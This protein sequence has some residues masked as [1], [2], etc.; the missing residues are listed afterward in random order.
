MTWKDPRDSFFEEPEEENEQT[1]LPEGTGMVE[2]PGVGMVPRAMMDEGIFHVGGTDPAQD[3]EAMFVV[4]PWLRLMLDRVMGRF[5]EEELP[6]G[7]NI[8]AW[9]DRSLY[10][11]QLHGPVVGRG[12]MGNTI[13][14]SH[15]LEFDKQTIRNASEEVAE[16]TLYT[17]LGEVFA[18]IGEHGP[19]PPGMEEMR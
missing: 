5:S 12:A 13:S 16:W 6:Q 1:P 17:A 18:L 9:Q 3:R 2:I 8:Q 10:Y 15:E 19:F 14:A 4:P 11:I 7:W